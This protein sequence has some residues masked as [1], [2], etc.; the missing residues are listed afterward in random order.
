MWE[1][2]L[3]KFIKKKKKRKRMKNKWMDGWVVMYTYKMRVHKTK[4]K[5]KKI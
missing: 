3:I 2:F 4:K 5:R 1:N